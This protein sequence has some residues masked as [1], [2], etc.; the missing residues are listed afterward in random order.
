[1]PDFRWVGVRILKNALYPL[2]DRRNKIDSFFVE[3]QP[4]EL[5]SWWQWEITMAERLDVSKVL[6]WLENDEFGLSP[7]KQK[8]MGVL[9]APSE[10]PV[11]EF[12][13]QTDHLQRSVTALTRAMM[14]LPQDFLLCCWKARI[15]VL[16]V[17]NI[18]KSYFLSWWQ[19]HW[20]QWHC[21]TTLSPLCV[22]V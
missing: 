8:S 9:P 4:P 22:F 2:I 18:S 19:W 21:C 5:R 15:S 1:M 6:L 17:Q 10:I 14:M 3:G 13:V 12:V 11:N 7:G 16:A 20:W